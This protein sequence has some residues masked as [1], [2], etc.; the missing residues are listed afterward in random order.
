M[1]AVYYQLEEKGPKAK[2][3]QKGSKGPAIGPTEPKIH[4]QI[5]HPPQYTP[6]YP[7]LPQYTP[8][9]PNIS[10]YTPIYPKVGGAP[11]LKGKTHGRVCN[12]VASFSTASSKC[13]G[14]GNAIIR[15]AA[16]NWRIQITTSSSPQPKQKC[17]SSSSI[18]EK[19]RPSNGQRND[20]AVASY[21]GPIIHGT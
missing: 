17:S 10:H 21:S 15:K 12:Y 13:P 6:T 19:C 1:L 7:N 9:Y 16:E 2:G 3:Q 14:L 18:S 8:L 4:S 5:P 11:K 20:P